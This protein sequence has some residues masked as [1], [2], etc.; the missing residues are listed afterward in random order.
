MLSKLYGKINRRGFTLIELMIVIAIIGIL[1]AIA[2]PQFVAYRQ[3]AFNTAA[4]ADIKSA[5]TAAELYLTANPE[6][7]VT[8]AIVKANGYQQTDGV[9]LTVLDGSI[10]GLSMTT[11]HAKGTLTYTIDA[12]GK[13]TAS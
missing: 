10:A 9:T 12:E 1:A 8:V 5:Y 11:I 2:V 3:K 13:I 6:G 7:T 4:N